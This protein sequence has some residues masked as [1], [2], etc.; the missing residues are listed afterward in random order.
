[1]KALYKKPEETSKCPRQT[2][3]RK[4]PNYKFLG[5]EAEETGDPRCFYETRVIESNSK[6]E[7]VNVQRKEN[8]LFGASKRAFASIPPKHL[9]GLVPPV[10]MPSQ[11][12][13]QRK[14]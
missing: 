10:F 11:F 5:R 13:G 3:E 2:K 14:F 1:M 12:E 6:S 7:I 4:T 8:K 9:T